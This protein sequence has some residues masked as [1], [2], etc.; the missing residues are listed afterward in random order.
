MEQQKMASVTNLRDDPLVVI[1][2]SLDRI[3]QSDAAH[4]AVVITYRDGQQVVLRAVSPGGV[5]LLKAEGFQ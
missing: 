3:V 2:Q 1:K 5:D 4:A